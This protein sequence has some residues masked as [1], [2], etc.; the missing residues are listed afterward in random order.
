MLPSGIAGPFY[1]SLSSW[2]I[3]VIDGLLLIIAHATM[4]PMGEGCYSAPSNSFYRYI[5]DSKYVYGVW[6]MEVHNTYAVHKIIIHN[7]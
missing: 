5:Y 2:S 1:I 4:Q 7:H 6:L 3:N